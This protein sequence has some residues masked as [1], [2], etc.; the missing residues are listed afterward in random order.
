MVIYVSPGNQ[1][2]EMFDWGSR[3]SV[4]ASTANALALMHQELQNDGIAHGNL[5][6]SNILM[7][8]DMDP[9]ISEYGLMMVE[10]HDEQFTTQIESIMDDD[11][12]GNKKIFKAD[13]YSFGVIL[14][15]LLTGKLVENRASDLAK[16]VHSVVREEWTAEVFDK[17]L[18]SE[19]A[20]EE[21]MVNLLQVALRC[22][23]PSLDA[24]PSSSQVA[25]MI[26]SIKGD[27]EKSTNTSIEL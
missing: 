13:I 1:K 10:N 4:A 12:Q 27:E 17:A 19:G 23:N 14:L 2:G 7:N 5:K 6:S 24:R 8:K 26:N 9:C 18:I 22:I 20:S 21:R 3:L 25:V 11:S 16:W 15:E